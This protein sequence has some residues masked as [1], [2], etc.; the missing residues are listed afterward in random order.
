[1]G[2][3][4]SLDAAITQHV[5]TIHRAA[6]ACPPGGGPEWDGLL[7][8]YG[9]APLDHG[10]R[11]FIVTHM[12]LSRGAVPA[13]VRA[14]F[15]GLQKWAHGEMD[16]LKNAGQP[17]PPHLHQRISAL[18]DYETS[19]Y[20]R[21]IGVAPPPPPAAVAA[22]PPA[23]APPPGTPAL[24]SIFANAQSTSKEVPWAN[25]KYNAVQT[26][27]CVHC[28]GPQEQPQDFMC[29]YCRRPIA[30]ERKT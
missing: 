21:S 20:E 14:A 8:H 12:R 26:L 3:I 29:R 18:V 4:E 6:S 1:M 22:P 24:A 2:P 23:Y 19:T 15:A 25:Q 7:R 13:E 27:N 9:L 16:R 30:G 11:T 10:E 17:A 28:G 5:Q